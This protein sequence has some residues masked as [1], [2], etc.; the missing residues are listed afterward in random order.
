M[1]D[2]GEAEVEFEL[3]AVGCTVREDIYEGSKLGPKRDLT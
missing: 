1:E 2:A 3:P